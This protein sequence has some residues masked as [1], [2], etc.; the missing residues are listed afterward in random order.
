[1]S[2]S[3]QPSRLQTLFEDDAIGEQSETLGDEIRPSSWFIA[4]ASL[5]SALVLGLFAYWFVTAGA[6]EKATHD[7]QLVGER[8]GQLQRGAVVQLAGIEIGRVVNVSASVGE[9]IATV[10]LEASIADKLTADSTF[11]IKPLQQS[12]QRNLGVEV[13]AGSQVGSRLPDRVVVAASESLI[14][15]A[16]S[17]LQHVLDEPLNQETFFDI[18]TTQPTLGVLVA[19]LLTAAVAPFLRIAKRVAAAIILAALVVLVL[20]QTE[21]VPTVWEN[22]TQAA[23]E[24]SR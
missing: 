9:P 10:D 17:G 8:V 18:G 22:F 4:G 14:A 3:T 6:E 13:V 21:V 1:M 20:T 23:D 24:L 16:V 2:R 15:Q 7:L 12:E 11:R 5:L 19:L